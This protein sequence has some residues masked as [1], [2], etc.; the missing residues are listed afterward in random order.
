[1]SIRATHKLPNINYN[2]MN[3]QELRLH[4]DMT[5]VVELVEAGQF[6]SLVTVDA[7]LD[8]LAVRAEELGSFLPESYVQTVKLRAVNVALERTENHALYKAE[9]EGMMKQAASQIKAGNRSNYWQLSDQIHDYCA[10]HRLSTDEIDALDKRAN[11]SPFVYRGG[12][13]KPA[14]S[15]APKVVNPFVNT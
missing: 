5:R 6:E 10:E 3:R 11:Q 2:Q 8:H 7:A 14:T 13:Y 9:A 1:M 4:E 15:K 12:P